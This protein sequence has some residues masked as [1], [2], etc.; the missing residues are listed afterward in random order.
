MYVTSIGIQLSI[1]SNKEQCVT[2]DN[3]Q[4]LCIA[5]LQCTIKKY[6]CSTRFVVTNLRTS[7]VTSIGDITREK[8]VMLLILTSN[9]FTMIQI[10]TQCFFFRKDNNADNG[11]SGVS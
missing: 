11:N 5:F 2:F 8:N 6:L 3:Y 1:M 9:Q 10:F 4:T 7:N